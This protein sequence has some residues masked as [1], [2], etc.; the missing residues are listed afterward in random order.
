MDRLQTM[1]TF[2]RVVDEGGFAAAARV[3]EVDQALVTRQVA[4]LERTQW[5]SRA[6][7]EALQLQ[8]LAANLDAVQAGGDTAST[9]LFV[10]VAA[11]LIV[12]IIFLLEGRI[13]IKKK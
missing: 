12:L 11:L 1:K 3:M 2:V 7:M 4:D 13:E 5:L 8:R 6:E 10:V 9:L